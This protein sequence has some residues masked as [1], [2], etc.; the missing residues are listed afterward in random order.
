MR[1]GKRNINEENS[2]AIEESTKLKWIASLV[3]LMKML[4][5]FKERQAALRRYQNEENMEK[6]YFTVKEISNYTGIAPTTLY[7]MSSQ[8]RIP[9]LKIGKSVRFDIQAIEKWLKQF[10]REVYE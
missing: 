3:N 2:I 10:K 4:F 6:R 7:E 9:S 5:P 1:N 8:R